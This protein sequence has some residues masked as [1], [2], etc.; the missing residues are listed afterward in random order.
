[1]WATSIH[2][3]GARIGEASLTGRGGM[4]DMEDMEGPGGNQVETSSYS[5]S[6]F[7]SYIPHVSPI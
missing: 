6:R 5:P 3:G 2:G 7:D 1:M 4:E